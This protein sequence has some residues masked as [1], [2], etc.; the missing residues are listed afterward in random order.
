[1]HSFFLVGN[2]KSL[3]DAMEKGVDLRE[4]IWKLYEDY[5]CGG[6]MKLVVIGGGI[7]SLFHLST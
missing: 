2:K 5:Y 4:Q 3:F 6:L 1:M 7:V